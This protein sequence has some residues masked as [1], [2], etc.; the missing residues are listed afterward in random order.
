[1]NEKTA[2]NWLWPMEHSHL[3]PL[4]FPWNWPKNQGNWWRIE[5]DITKTEFHCQVSGSKTWFWWYLTQFF[6]NFL[7]VLL[8]VCII[9]M[10]MFPNNDLDVLWP[11]GTLVFTHMYWNWLRLVTVGFLRFFL[12]LVQ[13]F[14]YFL[15]SIT[16][17]GS[18]PAKYGVKTRTGLDF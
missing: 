10:I 5:W 9:G 17:P 11:V 8:S 16:S 2:Q 13:F 12:V 1:M 18:G 7:N 14:G 3:F 6:T 4:Q 15:L